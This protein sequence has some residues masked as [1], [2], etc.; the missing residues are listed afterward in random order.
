[1]GFLDRLFNRKEE[2][3]PET[4]KSVVTESA[5][6]TGIKPLTYSQTHG[7]TKTLGV[8]IDDVMLGSPRVKSNASK[9]QES[10][11]EDIR[12]YILMDQAQEAKRQGDT[13]KFEEL[14][15]RA[16]HEKSLLQ[17]PEFKALV[18]EAYTKA[19]ETGLKY[20]DPGYQAAFNEVMVKAEE[21]TPNVA[22]RLSDVTEKMHR[23]D[24][25]ETS[26]VVAEPTVQQTTLTPEQIR[27]QREDHYQK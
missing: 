21:M 26:S 1:M 18:L 11:A 3:K 27:G 16:I 19:K 25:K 23:N 5:H 12:Q 15:K 20:T 9:S 24:V 8:Y 6:F 2:K 22:Q 4:T 7:N 14:K 17:E 13:Q 10:I